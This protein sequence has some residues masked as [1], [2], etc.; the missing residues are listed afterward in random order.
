ME[1]IEV[2]TAD[3]T[4][5]GHCFFPAGE[6][7]F[8]LVLFFMD[9]GGLRPAIAAMGER[10]AAAGY[11]VVQ[12]NLYWR[13]G[14]FEPFDTL[15]LFSDPGQRTRVMALMNA[16]QPEQALREASVDYALELYEGAQHGFAMTDFPVYDEAASERHCQRVLALFAE[17]LRQSWRGRGLCRRATSAG[18]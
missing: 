13:S 17:T 18:P 6:G 1:H 9:A 10:L 15:T 4:A 8:P 3:G 16:V 11:A 14:P 5:D 7:P 2:Q 12:P